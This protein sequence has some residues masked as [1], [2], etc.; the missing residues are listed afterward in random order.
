MSQKISQN[1]NIEI[2]NFFLVENFFLGLSHFSLVRLLTRLMKRRVEKINFQ[3]LLGIIIDPIDSKC[4]RM[5]QH[6]M[7]FS[8]WLSLCSPKGF[9]LHCTLIVFL[10]L[11][12]Y[13]RQ[14]HVAYLL[15]KQKTTCAK[16]CYFRRNF[17]PFFEESQFGYL[18]I[19]FRIYLSPRKV[20]VWTEN[21]L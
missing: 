11:K 17:L 19:R 8:I 20:C 7:N 2:E 1:E 9:I 21:L 13:V 3:H 10:K 4:R 15:F 6:C 16:V 14:N 18:E 12:N 5:S